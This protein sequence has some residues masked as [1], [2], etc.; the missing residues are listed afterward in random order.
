MLYLGQRSRA[1]NWPKEGVV[2]KD[3][4]RKW[5]NRESQKALE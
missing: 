2:R 3:P 4:K 1:C 5:K